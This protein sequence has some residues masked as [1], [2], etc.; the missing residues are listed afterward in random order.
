MANTPSVNVTVTPISDDFF[1]N[2]KIGDITL[3]S[4][5]ETALGNNFGGTKVSGHAEKLKSVILASPDYEKEKAVV[6]VKL[7]TGEIVT[8]EKIVS[9]ASERITV[10]KAIATWKENKSGT[11][12]GSTSA[13]ISF[14]KLVKPTAPNNG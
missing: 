7:A 5:V 8:L 12:A 6:A 2:T 9:L 14:A 11:T 1:V 13:G 10:E 3:K 4:L